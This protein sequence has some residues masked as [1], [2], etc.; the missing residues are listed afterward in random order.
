VN[1]TPWPTECCERLKTLLA[2]GMDYRAIAT[3]LGVT[4]NAVTGK[5]ARLGLERP[6]AGPPPPSFEQ[7]RV[8]A[9]GCVWVEGDPRQPDWR[10]CGAEREPGT[11]WCAE[12]RRRAY[13][14]KPPAILK[15]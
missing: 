3:E 11:A 10:W 7:D 4:R 8:V 2:T 15:P 1:N 14:A 5:I 9:K 13:G 6:D 12:H